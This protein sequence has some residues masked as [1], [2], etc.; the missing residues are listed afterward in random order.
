MPTVCTCVYPYSVLC[1][2]LFGTGTYMFVLLVL[3]ALLYTYVL[4]D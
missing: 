1:S 4:T 3:L 2:V